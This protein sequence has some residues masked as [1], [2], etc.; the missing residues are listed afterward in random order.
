C[1][2]LILVVER[3]EF[4]GAQALHIPDVEKLMAHQAEPGEVIL[5]YPR[6]PATG[7]EDSRVLVSETTAGLGN[8]IEEDVFLI[9]QKSP[10]VTMGAHNFFHILRS[11][12]AIPDTTFAFIDQ[13]VGDSVDL[14]CVHSGIASKNRR[15]NERVEIGSAV[16][17]RCPTGR[18]GKSSDRSLPNIGEDQVHVMGSRDILDQSQK[19]GSTVKEGEAVLNPV[20]TYG[21]FTT[22]DTICYCDCLGVVGVDTPA[23]LARFVQAEPCAIRSAR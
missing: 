6:V 4:N 16:V 1:I 15:V 10:H 12:P 17:M 23:V 2:N 3:A 19:R 9:W 11:A 8:H 21:H 5:A 22:V 18:C 14:E 7:H 13:I 20:S